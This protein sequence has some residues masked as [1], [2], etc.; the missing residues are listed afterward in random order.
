MTTVGLETSH[1]CWFGSC[2]SF[3][4]WRCQ[5]ARAA[6]YTVTD[7]IDKPWAVIEIP[8]IMFRPENYKGEWANGPA[9]EDP[10]LYLFVHSDIDGVIHPS[11]GRHLAERLEQILPALNIE[12]ASH[13]A[14]RYEQFVPGLTV[15]RMTQ[16]ALEKVTRRFIKGLRVA[17]DAGEDVVFF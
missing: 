1:D 17:A 9:V 15:G 14:E 13:T 2:T 6:D 16:A 5:I 3:G 4:F 10:L 11:E 7:R 8:G 12:G